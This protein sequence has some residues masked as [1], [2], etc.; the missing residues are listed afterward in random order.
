MP[1]PIQHNAPTAATFTTF[2]RLPDREPG[3]QQHGYLF[4]PQRSPEA[5][6]ETPARTPTEEAD[7]RAAEGDDDRM[8]QDF[9]AVDFDP[10]L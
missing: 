6:R 5:P 4:S 2:T 1:T 3:E 10:L 7:E 8:S 9:N